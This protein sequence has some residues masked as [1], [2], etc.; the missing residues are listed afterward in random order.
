[1]TRSHQMLVVHPERCTGCGLCEVACS[2]HREGVCS[3][4]LARIRIL[5]QEDRGLS[6]PVVCMQCTQAPCRAVCPMEAIG[7][8]SATGAITID[9]QLCIGCR[10]CLQACPLGAISFHEEAQTG[11]ILKCDLC[12]GEPRCIPFCGSEALALVQREA[13]G[14]PQRRQALA[15]FLTAVARQGHGA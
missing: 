10:L 6:L 11:P 5:R 4:S 3:R 7:R 1:M 14:M 12:G 2:L 15:Q 9:R 13:L 8:D